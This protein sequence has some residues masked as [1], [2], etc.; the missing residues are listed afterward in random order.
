MDR[1]LLKAKLDQLEARLQFLIEGSAAKIFPFRGERYELA[2][3]LVTA[4]KAGI[5]STEDGSW[6]AP[7][8]YTI[9]V[10][11]VNL[12]SLGQ[13]QI[14]LEELAEIIRQAGNEA[15]LLFPY[16]PVI[17]VWADQEVGVAEI[18]VLVEIST[19]EISE[20]STL[21]VEPDGDAGSIPANACLILEGA[22]VFPLRGAVVNIG[23]QLD[24]HLVINMSP[25]SRYHAQLRA[26][27]GRY[28]IFDLD[29]TGGTYV[30][31]RRLQQCTLYSG[32]VISIAG[33][34]LV[35]SQD[36]NLLSA[37][38]PGPTQP[39]TPFPPED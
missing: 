8:L 15:G 27:K 4:M 12:Q 19:P 28:V 25:I 7:N 1:Q 34:N 31:G 26:I 5:R 6:L 36:G 9:Q 37:D 30:N 35:Y 17:R 22:Q 20:T 14:L 16:P 21:A 3:S 10:H 38:V 39:I 32:D 2:S 24:N 29:S 33:V 18:R 13:N 23:R 11:P